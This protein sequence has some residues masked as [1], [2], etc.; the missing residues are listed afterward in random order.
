MRRIQRSAYLNEQGVIPLL[1][2]VSVVGVLLFLAISTTFSFQNN[3]FA[4]LYKKS[5]PFASGPVITPSPTARPVLVTVNIP[6][7]AGTNQFA[8]PVLPVVT[9]DARA[10]V[11]G[12][13]SSTHATDVTLTKWAG[14][15]SQPLSYK[16]N[17]QGTDFDLEVG[18]GYL[19]KTNVAGVLTL[20]GR[21]I[22]QAPALH[23]V[24]GWN[25]VAF[26]TAV[27]QTSQAVLDNI[28]SS[29]NFSLPIGIA[30]WNGSTWVAT[31]KLTT[32]NSFAG[33]NFTIDTR[34][35][36]F[37]KVANAGIYTASFTT[38][39][40]AQAPVFSQL[41]QSLLGTPPS[42]NQ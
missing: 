40:S 10:I 5:T 17:G 2:L 18:A 7:Q 22:T 3:L 27:A 16:S 28:F 25:L 34:K 21:A 24:A 35:G 29:H 6:L 36:Y 9:L 31:A 32:P 30:Y 15:A 12:V 38:N 1:V 37:V 23:L 13:V 11:N 4:Q 33:A 20:T 26:P 39:N 41:D 19:I 14:Q 42:I 8:L